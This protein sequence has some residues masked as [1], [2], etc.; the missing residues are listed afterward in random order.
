MLVQPLAV[1]PA[2]FGTVEFARAPEL[3]I[4]TA[5]WPDGRRKIAF[6]LA[7]WLVPTD[8]K[9]VW[10]SREVDPDSGRILSPWPGRRE[11]VWGQAPDDSEVE[12]FAVPDWSLICGEVDRFHAALPGPAPVLKWDVLLTDQGP[13]LLE[14]NV[15]TNIYVV[16]A[17]TLRPITESAIG[18]ALEAWA[19]WRS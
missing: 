17:M 13:R 8:G 16:Q 12:P 5:E 18:E 10:R 2:Q 3:S 7:S 11:P 14:T 1:P 6:V 15:G 19:R 4:F 9:T